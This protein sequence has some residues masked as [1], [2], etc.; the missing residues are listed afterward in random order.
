M[1]IFDALND[2]DNMKST[3]RFVKE[4]G[5]MADCAVCY[6]VDPQ[7]HPRRARPGLPAGQA[8]AQAASSPSTTS[9]S[10]AEQLAGLGADMITIK[11]MAGLIDPADDGAS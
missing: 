10:K 2:I 7:L 1:R 8:A 5:G 11:D 3:I 6:T 9:S 4:N